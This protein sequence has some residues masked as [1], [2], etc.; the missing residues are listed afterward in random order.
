MSLSVASFRYRNVLKEHGGPIESIEIGTTEVGGMSMYQAN[1]LLCGNIVPKRK[2]TA[3][4]AIADGSGTHTSVSVARHIAVSEALERWA[5]ISVSQTAQRA[6]YGFD[7]DPTS[8]GMAA[9]PGLMAKQARRFAWLEAVERHC[10][11]GWWE[12]LYRG[13]F[14]TTRWD[15]IHA[16]QIEGPFA[17]Q[18]VVLYGPTQDGNRYIYGHAAGADFEEAVLRAIIELKRHEAALTHYSG[19]DPT[20]R[21][22]RR[23]LYFSRPEGF[24][25]FWQRVKDDSLNLSPG[26][27]PAPPRVVYDGEIPGPW[28]KYTHVWRVAFRPISSRFLEDGDRYFFW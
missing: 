2:A 18:A 26:V 14:R 13:I 15:E 24:A 11:F 3:L 8:N 16:I 23:A 28:S 10:L 6:S 1:A 22:E 12:G 21:L 5:M 17:E 20:R 27:R 4:F 19:R 7:L 25:E 9:F